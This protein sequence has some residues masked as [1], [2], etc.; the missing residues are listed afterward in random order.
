MSSSNLQIPGI[1]F[2]EFVADFEA[3]E[4]YRDGEKVK[5][6]GQPFEV[7]A[8]LLTRP[9]RIVT[10]DDFRRRLWPT[11]TFV[12]FEHGLN[13]AV[14][15][16]RE[17]LGDSAD[18]PR[19]IETLPRRGYRFIG[20]SNAPSVA[21]ACP[22]YDANLAEGTHSLRGRLRRNSHFLYFVAVA[23]LLA[24]AAVI[25]YV[26]LRPSRQPQVVRYHQVTRDSQAKTSSYVSELL[27]PMV[28]D[29]SQLYF[30]AGP[31]GN[32]RLMQVSMAGGETA[33]FTAPLG[34]RRIVA[35]SADRHELLVLVSSDDPLQ[36]ETPLAVLPLPA[37]APHRVGNVLAHDASWSADGTK[38]AYANGNDLYV[39]KS[40]GTE[41]R[42]LAPL[43]ATAWWPRWSPDGKAVRFTVLDESGVSSLWEVSSDGSHL[44]R[45]L[46]E[47]VEPLSQCCGS[48]TTDGRYFVFASTF[49]SE[50]Q[51][52]AVR[53]GDRR[54]GNARELTRLSTGPTDLFAPL[55]SLDGK[56]LFA[57]T[58]QPRGQLVRYDARI[59]QFLPFLSG[60]S[61]QDVD[62]SA[63]GR[64]VT[65]VSVPERTLWRS[66]SDGSERLQLTLSPMS[67]SLPRWSP[68]GSRI[69]FV[70]QAAAKKPFKIYLISRD[71]GLPEQAMAGDANE[72]EPSWSPDGH[73]IVFG[74]WY[75]LERDLAPW[76][77]L[78]D[79]GTRQVTTVQG[80]QG[81]HSAR[82]SPDG[83]YIA[84]LTSDPSQNLVLFDLESHK[85]R[86]LSERAAY[87]NWSRDGRH[88]YFARPYSDNPG[89]YRVRIADGNVEKI[90]TLDPRVLNWSIVGKWTGLAPD[91]SP[92]VLRDTSVEEI[93]ALEWQAP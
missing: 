47:D 10:R 48:W 82:W 36:F 18:A 69:A 28:S 63:D 65:Y 59:G 13:A 43:P 88:I 83:R 41:S 92:L 1:R 44:H 56:Q 34:I 93:Y 11:D 25:G 24:A 2:G 80:S 8:L 62:F 70:A 73:S 5:L 31:L 33:S 19:Y 72:G 77:K 23:M 52:W 57:I 27:S 61:A 38:I 3:R 79:L 64:W 71:G 75:W 53:D 50:S 51:L 86:E 40:D 67:A 85:R 22:D 30:M 9:G 55:P 4:L 78:L 46:P 49:F 32:K 60:I 76:L 35:A 45:L 15:R 87:P 26:Y 17:A 54:I 12:D 6:Q 90:T 37:G 39:A 91:D 21:V 66:K 89:L 81:T 16:L 7:L 29:G 84:A 14:N 58:T 74:I 68:D 20:S 42:K